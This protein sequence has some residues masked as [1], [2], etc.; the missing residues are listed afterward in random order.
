MVDRNLKSIQELQHI[1]KQEEINKRTVEKISL[2]ITKAFLKTNHRFHSQ[3]MAFVFQKKKKARLVI[4]WPKIDK[5][6]VQRFIKGW[7]EK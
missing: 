6:A 4:E 2:E 5:I 1:E 7:F 3:E